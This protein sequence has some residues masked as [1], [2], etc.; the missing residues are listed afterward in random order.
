ML[1]FDVLRGRRVRME[2]VVS[3]VGRGKRQA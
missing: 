2:E 1:T 3:V